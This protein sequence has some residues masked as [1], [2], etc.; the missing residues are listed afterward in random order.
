MDSLSNGEMNAGVVYEESVRSEFWA[1]HANQLKAT[2]NASNE[3]R[4]RIPLDVL[5]NTFQIKT[6]GTDKPVSLRAKS[7]T[8]SLLPRRWTNRKHRPLSLSQWDSN[9]RSYESARLD[10]DGAHWLA[11]SYPINAGEDLK[12]ENPGL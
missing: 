1:S 7:D 10:C 12:P 4:H 6:P 9:T 11:I 3:T 5:V 8:T 2:S